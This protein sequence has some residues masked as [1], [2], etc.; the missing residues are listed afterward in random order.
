[1]P[2]SGLYYLHL[3]DDTRWLAGAKVVVE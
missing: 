1:L 2:A 3:A